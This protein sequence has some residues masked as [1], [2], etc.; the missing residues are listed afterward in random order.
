MAV[1]PRIVSAGQR[2]T[3]RGSGFQPE[4]G[5]TLRFITT[6]SISFPV[7][8]LLAV[9]QRGEF[10]FMPDRPFNADFC[11][12]QGTIAAF[13]GSRDPLR[14]PPIADAPLSVAC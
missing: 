3:V 12:I 11:S 1:T 8:D 5:I 4:S 6:D 7:K 2:Y 10:T 14:D 13:D 9:D